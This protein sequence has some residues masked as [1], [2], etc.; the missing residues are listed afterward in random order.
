MH[1]ATL[2]HL[3]GILMIY[4]S[5][6]QVQPSNLWELEE[7]CG[8]T[9]S[10]KCP[11]RNARSHNGV[12][13]SSSTQLCGIEVFSLIVKLQECLAVHLHTPLGQDLFDTNHVPLCCFLFEWHNNV[14]SHFGIN[15]VICYLMLWYQCEGLVNTKSN[16]PFRNLKY[17]Q[18]YFRMMLNVKA[19]IQVSGLLDELALTW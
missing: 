9:L 18:M 3:S 6:S 19:N 17:P 13:H 8:F 5:G 15:T 16:I 12:P 11:Q 10:I 7:I 4:L 2:S 1:R 14:V